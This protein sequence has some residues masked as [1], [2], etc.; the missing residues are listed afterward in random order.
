MDTD[1]SIDIHAKFVD[2]KGKCH[3][4]GNPGDRA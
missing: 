4:H 2:M 1:K 3:I